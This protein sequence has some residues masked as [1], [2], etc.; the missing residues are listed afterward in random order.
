[1]SAARPAL[2]SAVRGVPLRDAGQL[3]PERRAAHDRTG[4]AR[5]DDRAA[6]GDG[7]LRGRVRRVDAGLRR[8]R[9]PVRATTDHA[10]RAGPARRSEPGDSRR[11]HR[12][13]AHRRPG[14]DGGRRRDDDPRIDGAGLPAV[15]RGRPPRPR[16]DPHL[17]RG[18]GRA[19]DR[20][21][22]GWVRAR[23]RAV[24]GPAAGERAD[25]RPGDHRCA[26][27][28]HCGRGG[29]PAPRPGGHRRCGAGHGDDRAC[30]RR[31][32]A[33]RE[34]RHRLV[35]AV[36][37][38]GGRPRGS[39]SLR[40]PRAL[41]PLPA[42]RPHPRRAPARCQR[43][44]VQ[45][46]D[47]AGDRGPRLHGDVAAA[48]RLGVAAR[49]RRHRD[50]AAG[51]RPRRGRRVRRPVRPTGRAGAGRMAQRR[52]GRGRARRLRSA[53]QL[54]VRVG[55][56]RTRARG[57]GDARR[58][59]RRGHQ[60]AARPAA[61]PDHDRR[62]PRRHRHRGQLRRRHRR[63]RHHP[64]GAVHRRHRHTELERAADRGVPGRGPDRRPDAHRYGRRARRLGL[65]PHVGLG[66]RRTAPQPGRPAPPAGADP[67]RHR[68][69]SRTGPLAALQAQRGGVECRTLMRCRSWSRS[70]SRSSC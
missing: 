40:P 18:P 2:R 54:R 47:R 11:Q 21:H 9:R 25:R 61:E 50:A 15:R 45:G 3:D 68:P 34:R 27:R 1:V 33:V 7:R 39:R 53:E 58:R 4:A 59:R 36:D 38:Y 13:T 37:G 17:D 56:G 14:G 64:R 60:R 5:F 51:R 69:T 29:R 10:H 62:G 6:V 31:T 12:G 63:H 23:D 32:H 16:D 19:R 52:D 57:G 46:R 44:G 70:G 30:A 35:G 66:G 8:G 22:R 65:R 67:H 26:V 42:P 43:T 24:A 49:A 48:A 20:P 41:G 55:R 28:R